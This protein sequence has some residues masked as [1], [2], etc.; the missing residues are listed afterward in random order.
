[1]KYLKS[2]WLFAGIA[3]LLVFVG[4]YQYLKSQKPL[5]I[6]LENFEKSYVYGEY[7]EDD[8]KS[9]KFKNAFK[10]A[11]EIASKREGIS[12]A[13]Y[14]NDPN[15]EDG[16]MKAFVG[17]AFLEEKENIDYDDLKKIEKQEMIFGKITN[18]YFEIPQ[19]IYM[20]MEDFAE[21]NALEIG[22]YSIEQYFSDTLMHV[23][24]PISYDE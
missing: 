5:E 23:F 24:M 4:F 13:L 11:D 14:Y 7:I 15:E 9:D 16:L 22:D 10:R 20:E 17:V 6:Q 3:L 2:K 19:R 21:T 8:W 18:D 1:M 12:T